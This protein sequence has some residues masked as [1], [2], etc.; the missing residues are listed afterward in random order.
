MHIY[1]DELFNRCLSLE[2]SILVVVSEFGHHRIS[3]RIKFNSKDTILILGLQ[4]QE[5]CPLGP[6]LMNL[7]QS[8]ELSTAGSNLTTDSKLKIKE[9][10]LPVVGSSKLN[11]VPGRSPYI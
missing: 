9:G 5:F 1:T 7:S 10:L 8:A 6:N 2:P 3:N 4:T 11:L